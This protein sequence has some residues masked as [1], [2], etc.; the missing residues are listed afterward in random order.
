MIVVHRSH[1]AH[2]CTTICEC[3]TS[4]IAFL[5]KARQSN[6]HTHT[7]VYIY[8]YIPTLAQYQTAIVRFTCLAMLGNYS[9]IDRV[10]NIGKPHILTTFGIVDFPI[11]V[12]AAITF[13]SLLHKSSLWEW[14]TFCKHRW[15]SVSE[16]HLIVL[17]CEPNTIHCQVVSIG[18]FI[19]SIMKYEKYDT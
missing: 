8:I 18:H 2:Q 7:H 5:Y 3:D 17:M 4:F 1:S 9:I 16:P 19:P 14:K 11:S 13:G 12:H 10:L 6:A 15:V